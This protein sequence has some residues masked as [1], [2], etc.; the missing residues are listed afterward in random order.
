MRLSETPPA[1]EWLE[2]FDSSWRPDAVELVDA[3]SLIGHS[4]FF[5]RLRDAIIERSGERSGPVGLFVERELGKFK[6]IPNRL[7]SESRGKHRRAFGT[8]PPP[9]KPRKT[10]DPEVGSEGLLATLV[11]G[12]CRESPGR[13]FSH[14]GPDQIRQRAIRALMIVTDFIGTGDQLM[15]YL[16]GA[17]RLRSVKSW[18]SRKQLEFEV[19]A[20]SATVQGAARVR[21]HPARPRL[22]FVQPCPT[23]DTVFTASRL[24][25]IK[26]LCI[27][28][29]PVKKDPIESLGY[30]GMGALIAF[31]HG[32]PN[33]AP[34]ILHRTRKGRWVPLFPGR[35]TAASHIAIGS[36]AE[37][38]RALDTRNVHSPWAGRVAKESEPMLEL[39][40]ALKVGPRLDEALAA[41]TGMTCAEVR[42]RLR[43]AAANGWIGKDRRLNDVGRAQL[44]HANFQRKPYGELLPSPVTPYYPKSLRSPR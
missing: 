11:T 44:I 39:L 29:D 2:Q 30:G 35:V 42:S 1:L 28:H 27:F 13:F 14:P 4:V 32:C 18:Y 40:T 9:V 25:R 12:L 22:N 26:D 34:R 17:W 15:N 6:G 3:M 20:Y 23:I 31:A 41:R 43:I 19:V 5:Q 8:G 16:E 37:R 36:V 33:N 21:S 24:Q 7:F 10:V 38:L